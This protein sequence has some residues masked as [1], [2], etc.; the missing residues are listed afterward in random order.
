MQVIK[1]D[2]DGDCLFHALGYSSGYDGGAL[3]I[4]VADFMEASADDQPGF[5][6]E[7]LLEA[8]MLRGGIWAGHTV[9]TAY[10]LMTG[11]RVMLRT[12]EAS[13][14]TALVEEVSHASVIGNE[15]ARTVHVLYNGNDHY[16]ALVEVFSLQG[17]A[18]AW[19]Q[20]PPPTYYTALPEE[21]PPLP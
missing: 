6:I 7:W 8:D 15:Q 18:P 10:S 12:L 19:P 17:M 9:I 5:E 21:F 3:R 14:G 13:T 11:A 16:D 1:V 4:D 20:P 2:G